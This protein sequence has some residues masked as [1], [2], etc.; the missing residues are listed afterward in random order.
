M[1]LAAGHGAVVL[2]GLQWVLMTLSPGSWTRCFLNELV[3]FGY[4]CSATAFS[5]TAKFQRSICS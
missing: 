5:K 4:V 1:V 2:P 3:C